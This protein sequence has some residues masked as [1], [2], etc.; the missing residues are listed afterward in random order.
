MDAGPEPGVLPGLFVVVHVLREEHA[1]DAVMQH[2]E[3]DGQ[4]ERTPVLVEDDHPYHHEEVEV[5]LDHTSR[6]MDED[7]RGRHQPQGR[8]DRA[9]PPPQPAPLGRHTRDGHDAGLDQGVG[10]AVAP[11]QREDEHD[12]QVEPQ[13]REDA[14]MAAAPHVV[15]E[16]AALGQRSTQA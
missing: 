12:R 4:Q 9:L 8:E 3:R 6:Q 13:Q 15:G 1:H 10:E 5:G 11:H 16:R 7:G 14:Q 2:H